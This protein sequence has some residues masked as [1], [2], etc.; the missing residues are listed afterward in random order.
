M[1]SDTANTNMGIKLELGTVSLVAE[2][3][4]IINPVNFTEGDPILI[5]SSNLIN[6]G[7]L[8]GKLAYKINIKKKSNDY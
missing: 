4:N 8:S 1:F 3:T 7:S 2:N 6:N 5:V